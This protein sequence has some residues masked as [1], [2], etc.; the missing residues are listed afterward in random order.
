MNQDSQRPAFKFTYRSIGVGALVGVGTYAAFRNHPSI[1]E[2]VQ[3][4][5]WLAIVPI[6]LLPSASVRFEAVR[7]LTV[8]AE[9]AECNQR[10]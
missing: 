10:R 3:Y 7:A 9:L 1:S 8:Q 4:G 5:T 2:I 6:S